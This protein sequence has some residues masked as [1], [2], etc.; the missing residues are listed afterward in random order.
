MVGIRKINNL[1]SNIFLF[2]KPKPKP[3]FRFSNIFFF[4]LPKTETAVWDEKNRKPNRL[5]NLQTVASQIYIEIV[6]IISLVT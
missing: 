2:A 3:R 5:S 1:L 4:F 6:I